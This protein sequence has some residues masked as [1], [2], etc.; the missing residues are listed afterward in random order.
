MNKC[1]IIKKVVKI[2]FRIEKGILNTIKICFEDELS[3]K[4]REN[5]D[6]CFKENKIKTIWGEKNR[7]LIVK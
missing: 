4:V 7:C 5:Y 3:R 6:K 2:N 1:E